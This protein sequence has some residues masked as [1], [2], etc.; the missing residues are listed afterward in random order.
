MK[1]HLAIFLLFLTNISYGQNTILNNRY[2]F[3]YDYCIFGSIIS[4]DSC[5]Y[6]KSLIS[7]QGLATDL[8]DGF[9]KINQDGTLNLIK[10]Y[11]EDTIGLSSWESNNLINTLDNN[12]AQLITTFTP[13]NNDFFIFIKQSLNGDTL[14]T[15]FL[16]TI[17]TLEQSTGGIRALWSG[18]MLQLEDSSYLCTANVQNL[19]WQNTYIKTVPMLIKLDKYGNYL[20]HK[21]YWSFISPYYNTSR[22]FSF[23]QF[24]DSTFV[25]CNSYGHD[26]TYSYIN[27]NGYSKFLF[28]DSTGNEKKTI[29]LNDSFNQMS[30]AYN[31]L[32]V[33]NDFI[34]SGIKRKFV[35]NS[36][37]WFYPI[38]AKIDTNFNQYWNIKLDTTIGFGVSK[39]N[40]IKQVTNTEFIAVGQGWIVSSDTNTCGMLVK[41]NVNG[42]LLWQRKYVKVPNPKFYTQQGLVYYNPPSHELSDV[43]ITPDSGFVMVGQAVNNNQN[44]SEPYGQMGWLV[45][46]DK[47]GCLVPGCEIYDNVIP[48]DTTIFVIDTNNTDT[49]QTTTPPNMLYPNPATTELYYYHQGSSASPF[50]VFIYDLQGQVVQQFT[51]SGNNITYIIDI[52]QLA[53]AIYIFKVISDS[54]EVIMSEKFVKVE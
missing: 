11:A 47:H 49:T 43:D 10:E 50:N 7:N 51:V 24:N 13:S 3:G 1:K 34:Y 23:L 32:K 28:I 53:S 26:D 37:V 27:D 20:W 4:T 38:I 31:F 52:S 39:L 21:I 19:N 30:V 40:E 36:E 15:T 8:K 44:I 45:K 6:I 12:F 16:D 54:G 33:N 41:F 35:S 17:N 48:I 2:S 25:L 42:D 46:T 5:Y 18:K 29:F 22:C 9:I 14:K